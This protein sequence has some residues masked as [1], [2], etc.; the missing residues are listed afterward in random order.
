MAR[1]FSILFT[2]VLAAI[3]VLPT[4]G[5]NQQKVSLISAILRNLVEA[6][7]N[8]ILKYQIIFFISWKYLLVEIS[9]PG[10]GK[11]RQY[12][13]GEFAQAASYVKDFA[14][15]VANAASSVAQG[16]LNTFDKALQ[17]NVPPAIN[18][19]SF[20]GGNSASGNMGN[21]G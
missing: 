16:A 14:S 12:A 20:G 10:K 18:P 19:S 11:A 2:A 7:S 6:N 13:G 21:M 3:F 4:N 15:G 8:F 9:E 1:Y 5:R 17:N